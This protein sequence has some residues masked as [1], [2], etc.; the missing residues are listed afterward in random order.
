MLSLLLLLPLSQAAPTLEPGMVLDVGVALTMEERQVVH[1]ARIL[2]GSDG[3]ILKVGRQLDIELPEGWEHLSYPNSFAWPG[4]IDL[5]SHTHTG[6]WEDINDM[7]HPDNPEL[8]TLDTIVPDNKLHQMGR[9]GGVT[10]VN[11]IPGSGTNIS[12]AGT[13]VKLKVTDKV[14]DVVFRYPGSVKVAQGYNPERN[15][16]LGGTRMGMWWMLRWYLDR[17]KE[18]A[19]ADTLAEN[20]DV[21][22]I[23]GIFQHRYPFLVHTAGARDTFGTV[24]MFQIEAGVPVIV[25]HGSFNGF[26]AGEAIAEL[27]TPLNIGPRNF[28]YTVSRNSQF[29]GLVEAFE[30]AGNTDISVQTDAGVIPQEE[31]IYQAT[32]AERLGCSTWLA[33]ESI[34]VNPA[35]QILVEDQVG[36]LLPGLQADI[37][38]STGQP[39]DPRASVLL[40]LIEGEVAYDQSMG[41]LY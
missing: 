18:V 2:I 23:A 29:R 6:G 15:G 39:L 26:M 1:N 21:A 36:R 17:A 37:V 9:A 40:V 10:L 8:R 5:H 14:S 34:N 13:L 27:N 32:L 31:F 35:R 19:N 38:V 22:S 20:P 33:L 30:T 12:G 3:H 16:D 28:D 4:G 41:Q 11:A 24:R 25:S 7:V